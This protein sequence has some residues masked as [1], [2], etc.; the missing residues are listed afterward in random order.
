MKTPRRRLQEHTA[1]T[2][3]CPSG[4]QAVRT[5]SV[6]DEQGGASHAKAATEYPKTAAPARGAKRNA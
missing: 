4:G 6:T 1:A 3:G 2:S 5:P